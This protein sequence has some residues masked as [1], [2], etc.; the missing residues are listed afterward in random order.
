MKAEWSAGEELGILVLGFLA[1]VIAW[2]VLLFLRDIF[3]SLMHALAKRFL[4]PLEGLLLRW[5]QDRATARAFGT[6]V[7]VVRIRRKAD[8]GE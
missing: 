6:T 1:L 5:L 8:T 3:L 7:D 4:H 2:V